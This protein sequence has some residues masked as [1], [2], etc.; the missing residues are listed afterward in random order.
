MK[1][2]KLYGGIIR[3]RPKLPTAIAERKNAYPKL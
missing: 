2:K 1:E 3:T